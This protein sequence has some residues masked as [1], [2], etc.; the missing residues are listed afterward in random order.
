[1]AHENSGSS[2]LHPK[3]SSSNKLTAICQ[4][5]YFS[6]KLARKKGGA[7]RQTVFVNGR[8]WDSY[9]FDILRDEYLDIR[10]DLLKQTPKDKAEE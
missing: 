3:H 6:N 2:I 7:V 10:L 4:L 1:M 8:K 5:S 9:Y